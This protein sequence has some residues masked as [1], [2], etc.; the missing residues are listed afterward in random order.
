MKLLLIVL[1]KTEKLDELL[2]KMMDKG[3]T[4]ATIFNSTG[5][6]RELAKHSEDFPIFGTLR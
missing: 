4:G 6:A 3:I 2:E 1:N 5:M